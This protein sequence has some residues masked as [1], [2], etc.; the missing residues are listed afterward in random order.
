MN[1]GRRHGWLFA[2]G[3]FGQGTPNLKDLRIPLGA[4]YGREI[5]PIHPNCSSSTMSPK[6]A[7]TAL[8]S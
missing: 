2:A 3:I 7:P 6:N 4:Q 8:I 5:G 1:A